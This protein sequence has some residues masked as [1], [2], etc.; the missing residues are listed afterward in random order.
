MIHS[1]NTQI[2][3]IFA[4]LSMLISC[5]TAEKVFGIHGSEKLKPISN[6]FGDYKV[7][8]QAEVAPMVLRTKKGDRAVE[9]E[10]P[11]ESQN[12]SEF[13]LPVSPA[14]RE[15]SRSLASGLAMNSSD[16]GNSLIDESYKNHTPTLSDREITQSF[17]NYSSE[18]DSRIREIEKD[19]NLTPVEDSSS[20]QGSA[21][22][23]AQIDHV[24]QLYKLNRFEAAL[25]E[26]DE[27]IKIFPTDAK[28]YEM[29][30]TL[31]DRLERKELALRSWNQAL[32][33][34]PS[35]QRLRKFLERKQLGKPLGK[36]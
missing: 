11:G 19:L 14:F 29:R 13:V 6:P 24:K 18:N 12:L 30:G 27:M 26:T 17:K 34:D 22:Y 16:S 25:L 1:L 4:T 28:L 5:T 10:L 3:C 7:S 35:N 2:L 33:F 9:I 20:A 23:L 31:L 36:L 15:S 8:S 21:S 32:R